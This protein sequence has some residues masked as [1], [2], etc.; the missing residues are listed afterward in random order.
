MINKIYL[1]IVLTVLLFGNQGLCAGGAAG[2]ESAPQVPLHGATG[3]THGRVSSFLDPKSQAAFSRTSKASREDV[4]LG[5]EEHLLD[6]FQKAI[7]CKD[8]TSFCVVDGR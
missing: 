3:V 1:S 4:G 8:G 5:K 2:G 7:N 6:A